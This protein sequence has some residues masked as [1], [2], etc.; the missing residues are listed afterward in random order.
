MLHI[1]DQDKSGRKINKVLALKI[2]SIKKNIKNR[3]ASNGFFG[4]A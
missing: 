2:S 1:A 4:M 3:S